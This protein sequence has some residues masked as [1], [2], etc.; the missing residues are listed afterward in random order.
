MR[1]DENKKTIVLAK[2]NVTPNFTNN[3]L[4]L[5][6]GKYTIKQKVSSQVD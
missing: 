6:E 1:V 5:G 2:Y 3:G 4:V